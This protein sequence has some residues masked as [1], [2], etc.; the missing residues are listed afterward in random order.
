MLSGSNVPAQPAQ[1]AS[2]PRADHGPQQRAA[3]LDRIGVVVLQQADHLVVQLAVVATHA[4]HMR[5]RAVPVAI[6]RLAR[7]RS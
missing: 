1:Y 7:K 5:I 4:S 3:E 2:V 6:G